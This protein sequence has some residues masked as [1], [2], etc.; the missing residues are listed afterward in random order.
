MGLM[1]PETP[2]VMTEGIS[3]LGLSVL[4]K[5][6]CAF[7]SFGLVFSGILDQSQN[8]EGRSD[9][10][11]QSLIGPGELSFGTVVQMICRRPY[12][13]WMVLLTWGEG[14][15]PVGGNSSQEMTVPK[16]HNSRAGDTEAGSKH[17]W[18]NSRF[19]YRNHFFRSLTYCV[20][21]CTLIVN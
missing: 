16:I 5:C 14:L 17:L 8:C 19:L 21:F 1:V 9:P 6:V 15:L 7:T 12:G 10:I 11:Q 18:R 20:L 2:S 3:V 13:V 4:I